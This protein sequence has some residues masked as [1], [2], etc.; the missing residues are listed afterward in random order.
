MTFYIAGYPHHVGGA[1]QHLWGLI[2][3]WRSIGIDVVLLAK[4]GRKK[5]WHSRL[6]EL[7]VRF[8][9]AKKQWEAVGEGDIVGAWCS[10]T[11]CKRAVKFH[12]RG[13]RLVWNGCMTYAMADEL[14]VHATFRFDRVVVN[15]SYGESRLRPLLEKAYEYD[16]SHIVRIPTAFWADEWEFNPYHGPFTIG[17]LSRATE[18]KYD[19]SLWRMYGRIRDTLSGN[20]KARVMA[21]NEALE[22]MRGK[23][24]KWVECLKAKTEDAET[25][26]HSLSALVFFNGSAKENR[27]RVVFES[28]ACG[29]PVIVKNECG[30]RE[31][32]T[33]GETGFLC[34]DECH[35]VECAVR[36]ARDEEFRLRIARQARENLPNIADNHA[37]AEAW[38][39]LLEGLSDDARQAEAA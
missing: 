4:A 6:E 3:A 37:I 22:Q 36:L 24:P 20:C 2:R 9:P 33:H 5:D 15:S 21:W 1:G 7:G 8:A 13:C 35:A 27:S 32:I 18:D 14:P 11:F 28:M 12:E 23:P 17:R 30:F 39:T 31:Q 26:L 10:K 29:V 16:P 38:R 19:P 34:E 25:F